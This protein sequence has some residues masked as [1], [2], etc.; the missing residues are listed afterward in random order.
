MENL[1][2]V[3]SPSDPVETWITDFV[4][5][6]NPKFEGKSK[7]ERIKMALGAHYAA[8]NKNES[9]SDLRDNRIIELTVGAQH[10]GV[11]RHFIDLNEG[12]ASKSMLTIKDAWEQ[13]DSTLV[14]SEGITPGSE[15][16][17]KCIARLGACRVG[18]TFKGTW[19][20]AAFKHQLRLDLDGLPGATQHPTIFFDKNTKKLDI[21]K[22]FELL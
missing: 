11:V 12:I 9:V 20:Q 10:P 18:D 3:L 16:K 14:E 7:K 8:Q 17:V 5:S 22:S 1:N 21:P 19:K 15:G 13:F 4:K 2:E 6:T